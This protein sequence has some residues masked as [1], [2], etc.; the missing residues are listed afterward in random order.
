MAHV[1]EHVVISRTDSIGDVLLT[2]PMTGLLKRMHPGVK[3]TFIGR[4]YTAPVLAHGAHVDRIITYEEL[5]A[6][7][8][9]G[10]VRVLKD[11]GADTFVHVFPDRRLAGWARSAGIP[12][13]IGTSHRWW[14][15]F[16][17]DQRVDLGRRNS[18]LHEAQL[19][20]GLLKPLGLGAVPTL[21]ELVEAYGFTPPKPSDAV[22]AHLR[23]DRVN[24]ILH[25]GSRGSAV[26]W[27]LSNYAQLIYGLDPLRYH[28]L[29]TGTARER[30]GYA[31]RLPLDLSHVTDLGGA[32]GLEELIALIGEAQ[33]LVAAS[34][35]PLH[36]AAASGIRAIG[37]YSPRRPIHPGRW[38]PLGRDAH[39]LVYD[40][41]CAE[42]RKG[43]P[44]D[45]ITRIPHTAVRA[46]LDAI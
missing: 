44:C 41:A 27:G 13:R 39:A 19:N 16:T 3:V 43:G 46:L 38:A 26:E 17:C 25:P 9:K 11:L 22:R 32:F 42:C 10:A 7:G 20:T 24:V 33:A 23:P 18:D 30:E 40:P 35:G 28:C 45:C 37:L 36:I 5:Q 15:W 34:T 21:N 29:I 6:G 2:L 31:P 8:W 1:P 14:H 4:T 12:V